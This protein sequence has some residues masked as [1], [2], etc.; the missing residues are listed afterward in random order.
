[1]DGRWQK[2]ITAVSRRHQNMSSQFYLLRLT[3][4]GVSHVM[5]LSSVTRSGRRV[6]AQSASSA[7]SA[8]GKLAAVMDTLH[9][10]EPGY[11]SA[12]L[13]IQALPERTIFP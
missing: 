10:T 8:P 9:A 4:N 12:S 3:I 13:P 2:A 5:K 1:M 11:R 7:R 6:L